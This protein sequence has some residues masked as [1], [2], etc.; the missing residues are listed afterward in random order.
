MGYREDRAHSDKFIPAIKRLIGPNLIEVA[1]Q[2]ADMKEATDLVVLRAR[3][4]MI[5]AR[6]RR[7]GFAQ[8]Y[9]FDV[10]FRYSRSN[11]VTTEYDKIC[12]G[13]GDLFFY[14]HEA[15]E[16]AVPSIDL[17]WLID[18]HEFRFAR[19]D[20]E[21]RQSIQRHVVENKDGTTSF[22]VF[23][24]RSFP[25]NR[26][27]IIRAGSRSLEYTTLELPVQRATPASSTVKPFGDLFEDEP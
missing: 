1:S 3:D 11:G 17:W 9:P 4:V 22:I 23:D 10:T 15:P 24:L 12:R 25:T 6:I 5:A 2:D 19:A 16:A 20:L 21:C 26:V 27:K 8:R 18:L 14:G 13:W 7:P